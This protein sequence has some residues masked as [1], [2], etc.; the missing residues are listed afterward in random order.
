MLIA[1]NPIL[2]TITWD[3]S[4]A[5]LFTIDG[6]YQDANLRSFTGRENQYLGWRDWAEY[7]VR[8]IAEVVGHPD[9]KYYG[10]WRDENSLLW[11][12]ECGG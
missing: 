12:P 4:D 11:I 3:S 1:K 5:G 8:N 9:C 2:T 10:V 6:I 7:V